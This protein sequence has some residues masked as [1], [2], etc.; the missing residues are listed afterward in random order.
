MLTIFWRSESTRRAAIR[1][2]LP[3][4]PFV[5]SLPQTSFLTALLPTANTNLKILSTTRQLTEL[6]QL[7]LVKLG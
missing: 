4:L 6:S 2:L 7:K 3:N 1:S 5:A